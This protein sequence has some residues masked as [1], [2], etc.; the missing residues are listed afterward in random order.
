[1]SVREVGPVPVIDS[2]AR[3]IRS[4]A[5]YALGPM[6]DAAAEAG[7]AARAA[8]RPGGSAAYALAAELSQAEVL[9]TVLDPVRGLAL[10]RDLRA[11]AQASGMPELALGAGLNLLCGLVLQGRLDEATLLES[12]LVEEGYVPDDP[13]L[14]GLRSLLLPARGDLA[15]ALPLHQRRIALLGSIASLPDAKEVL[16][17][18]E[19]LVGNGLVDEALAL[20]RHYVTAFEK[21][22]GPLAYG[23]LASGAYLALAAA[24]RAGLPPD[25]DLLERADTML[26]NAAASLPPEAHRN[27]EGVDVLIARARRADLLGEPSVRAWREAYDACSRIG[28]GVALPVRLGWWRPC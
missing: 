27:W 13:W 3:Q 8:E 1:M 6:A 18:V 2:L 20:A 11:Q 16:Q 7:A 21:S 5:Y 28:A 26:A 15:A 10:A 17:H 12:E 23:C 24:Q 14:M 4:Q 25:E 9:L 22:D 19:V